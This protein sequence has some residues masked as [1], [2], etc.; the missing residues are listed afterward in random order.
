MRLLLLTLTLLL[1][2]CATR[3]PTTHTPPPSLAGIGRNV[4]AARSNVTKA[5]SYADKISEQVTRYKTEPAAAPS[6]VSQIESLNLAQKGELESAQQQLVDANQ[7]REAAQS[8]I[9]KLAAER[10][11]WQTFGSEQHDKLMKAETKVAEQKTKVLRLYLILAGIGA[12]IT[13]Y[14]FLK[15]YLRLPI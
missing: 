3:Q 7:A 8:E 5:R 15:F 11:Q 10:D 12:G 9:G 1:G 2:A 14:L 13:T 6:I 4:E